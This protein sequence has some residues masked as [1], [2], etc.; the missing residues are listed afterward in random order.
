[1]SQIK[2]V[3]VSF[4]SA[5]SSA[6]LIP[7]FQGFPGGTSGKEPACQCR[8]HKRP[9]LNPWVRKI[10]WGRAWQPT[11]VFLPGEFHG[12]RSLEGYSLLGHKESGMT[13]AICV[14]TCTPVF[15]VLCQRSWGR[16]EGLF[17]SSYSL[18]HQ[19]QSTTK[20]SCWRIQNLTTCHHLFCCNDCVANIIPTTTEA[21]QHRC[22]LLYLLWTHGRVSISQSMC[23]S[24]WSP[25]T[26]IPHV[27]VK[28][29]DLTTTLKV[30]G[31]WSSLSLSLHHLL[32]SQFPWWLRW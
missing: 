17:D 19:S 9:R 22:L 32:L 3:I 21:S 4:K 16:G 1:M 30:L 14:H 10:P 31:S 26:I 23:S 11:P 15:Q 12:Q 6:F 8:T 18:T 24:M 5:P 2:L 20:S 29:L 27:R 13:E 25:S 28:V 7:A